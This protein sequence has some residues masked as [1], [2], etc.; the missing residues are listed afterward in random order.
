MVI[1]HVHEHLIHAVVGEIFLSIERQV[2]AL[3]LPRVIDRRN[4]RPCDFFLICYL[5]HIEIRRIRNS[6][7][8]R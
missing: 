3:L 7:R 4:D 8:T 1:V 5:L 2:G 6:G